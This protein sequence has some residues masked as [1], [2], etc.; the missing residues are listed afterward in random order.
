MFEGFL[1]DTLIYWHVLNR[2][3]FPWRDQTD[4]YRVFVAEFFLQKTPAERVSIIFKRFITDYPT[5]KDLSNATFEKI[6]SEYPNLGLFKRIRWIIESSHLIETEFHSS[7][8]DN[9]ESLMKLP[10]I[11]DYTSSAILCFAFNKRI[12][13]VDSNVIRLY[14]RFFNITKEEVY[15]KSQRLL[16]KDKYKEYNEAILD[17]PSLICKKKPQCKICPLNI[18]CKYFN[19]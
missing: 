19:L 8:P 7:I 14:C 6:V 3:S 9:K 2:R 4:P 11:G 17:F 13:I 12:K 15:R 18:K 10:G 5:T 16:P 1:V